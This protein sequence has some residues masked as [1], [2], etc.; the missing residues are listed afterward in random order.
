M[1]CH[2]DYNL[3]GGLPAHPVHVQAHAH[4]CA[5]VHTRTVMCVALKIQFFKH[6]NRELWNKQKKTE[7]DIQINTTVAASES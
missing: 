4:T 2:A 5:R 3:S 1:E 6:A 7:M